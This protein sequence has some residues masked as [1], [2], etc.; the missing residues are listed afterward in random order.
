[1]TLKLKQPQLT[2]DLRSLCGRVANERGKVA[3]WAEGRRLR[4]F[5]RQ[6]MAEGENVVQITRWLAAEL[7]AAQ[8]AQRNG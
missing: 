8:A 6:R 4:D 3:I 5:A 2:P 1:M 7:E